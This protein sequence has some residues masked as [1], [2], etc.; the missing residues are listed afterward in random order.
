M[1]QS[2]Q[3]DWLRSEYFINIMT[4]QAITSSRIQ[5][6]PHYCLTG[7]FSAR[8]P[9]PWDFISHAYIHSHYMP[10]CGW[11]VK[12]EATI[13]QYV[14]IKQ[15]CLMVTFK[16]FLENDSLTIPFFRL[17]NTLKSLQWHHM[18]V[19]ASQITG[20]STVCSSFHSDVYQRKHHVPH[21]LPF[22]KGNH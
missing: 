10:G 8:K 9:I 22:V 20:D 6:A 16:Q 1:T 14:C 5:K 17:I 11:A 18:S 3:S 2:E 4:E 7:C 19:I 21:Y 13:G 12:I 15:G